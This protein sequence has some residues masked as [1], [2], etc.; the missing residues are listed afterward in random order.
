MDD[1]KSVSSA[2]SAAK[3][4][5]K[6]SNRI[7]YLAGCLTFF[8]GFIV[9]QIGGSIALRNEPNDTD[10]FEAL[11]WDGLRLEWCCGGSSISF[12]LAILAMLVMANRTRNRDAS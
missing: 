10:V 7:T 11:Y 6:S 4:G 9:L 1:T 8:A 12:I 2:S 5:G 3:A